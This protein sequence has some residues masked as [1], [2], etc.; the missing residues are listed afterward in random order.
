MVCVVSRIVADACSS[1]MLVSSYQEAW[2][3]VITDLDV[4]SDKPA[5]NK[6]DLV[7]LC[8]FFVALSH[9]EYVH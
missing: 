2:S 5:Q 6:L 8:P 7:I 9:F 1:D 4:L 3:T